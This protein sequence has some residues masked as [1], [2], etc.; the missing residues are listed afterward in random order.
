MYQAKAYHELMEE[1]RRA[2]LQPQTTAES[3]PVEKPAP[4]RAKQ[5]STGVTNEFV[6]ISA[7]H[8]RPHHPS[9][10]PDPSSGVQIFVCVTQ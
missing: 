7:K 1:A 4:V 10:M 5:V 2:R 9:V 3:M 8:R 6:N